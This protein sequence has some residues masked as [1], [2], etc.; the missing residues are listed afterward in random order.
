MAEA[1]PGAR[2]S[3][4]VGWRLLPIYLSAGILLAGNGL[5]VTLVAIRASAEGFGNTFIGLLGAGYFAG[6]LVACIVTPKLIQ[7]AGHIRVFAALSAGAAV[8]ALTM[9]MSVT[10]ETWLA[11]R[12]LSG[13]C[14]CGTATVLES[15][16]NAI[17]DNSNRGRLLGV[18]R[19]VDLGSVMGG[20]FVLPVIGTGGFQIFVF[21]GILLATA[22]IPV[23]LSRQASPAPPESAKVRPGLVW[24]ISPTAAFGCLTLGLTNSAF[25]AIGP[26]YAQEMGLG[27]DQVALFISLGVLG[28]ALLQYPIGVLSDRLDRRLIL[29]VTTGAAASASL[30]LAAA[31]SPIQVLIGGFLFGGFALPLYSLSMAHGND[32]AEPGQ[33]V[34]FTAG[35][36]LFYGLGAIVGPFISSVIIQEFGPRYFFTYTCAVHASLI[37]FVVWRMTRRASV[38][39]ALRRRYVG[40]LRT[41]PM[42]VRFAMGRPRWHQ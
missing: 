34:E 31:T 8:A 15:W 2:S 38:P 19:V 14:F 11:A 5:L 27:V 7:R 42:F 37:V 20:Q 41:S 36:I 10:P 32:H 13:F 39:P 21:A 3:T 24:A 35:L 29:I 25:R 16:L 6:F 1:R 23:S 30:F 28:G 4:V 9:I 18:Y 33:I 17:A 22:L 40:L 12:I 26:L